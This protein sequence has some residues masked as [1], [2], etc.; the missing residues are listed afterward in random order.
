MPMFRV[1]WPDRGQEQLDGPEV[2]AFDHEEAAKKWA[3]WYDNR[4]ADYAIVGGELAEVLVL[5]E[6]DAEPKR[7]S[8]Y[9]YTDRRYGIKPPNT[10]DKP[11]CEASSA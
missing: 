10:G 7:L 5:G 6:G 1:W 8:V 11:T 4:S 2:K 3:D 9:G